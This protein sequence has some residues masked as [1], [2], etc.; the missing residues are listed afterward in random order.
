MPRNNIAG[1]AK[2]AGHEAQQTPVDSH[3]LIQ[4]VQKGTLKFKLHDSLRNFIRK[5]LI[6]DDITQDTQIQKVYGYKYS[7]SE[8]SQLTLG[9]RVCWAPQRHLHIG[10]LHSQIASARKH[11]LLTGNSH[12]VGAKSAT[13]AQVAIQPPRA[14]LHA[15]MAGGPPTTVTPNVK[16]AA[17]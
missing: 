17:A 9:L 11:I 6:D 10:R 5:L 2:V 1:G 3:V 12:G 16:P 15:T 14:T 4:S 7:L 13:V 8:T